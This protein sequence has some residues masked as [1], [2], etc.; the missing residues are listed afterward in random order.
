M[1]TELIQ[2]VLEFYEKDEN[3]RICPWK[4][5]KGSVHD[6]NGKK[7]NYQKRLIL[8]NLKELHAALR[9][10]RKLGFQHLHLC[11]QSGVF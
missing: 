3:S 7:I 4:K 10:T 6:K 5:E 11:V 1:S 9:K 8:W 2:K